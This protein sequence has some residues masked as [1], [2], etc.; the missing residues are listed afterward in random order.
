VAVARVMIVGGGCRGRQLA[1][2][3]VADGHAVRLTT[4]SEDG[5]AA[6]EQTGAECWIGTPDRLATLRGALDSVTILCWVLGSAVGSEEELRALYT[7]RLQLFLTQAIDTTVRGFMYE[8]R[9]DVGEELLAEGERT[10][11]AITGRSSIPAA[12][13]DADPER[14]EEWLAHAQAAVEG[15]LT[16]A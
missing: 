3:L 2:R 10:V 6:I 12:V 13:L 15:L 5:R 4:R 8:S 14:T 9:G 16:R 1:M 11:R 7:T